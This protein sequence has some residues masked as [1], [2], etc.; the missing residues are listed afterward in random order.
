MPSVYNRQG[1]EQQR[2]R[3]ESVYNGF[4]NDATYGG[5]YGTAVATGV[6]YGSEPSEGVRGA[7]ATGSVRT[8]C[9]SV[10]AGFNGESGNSAA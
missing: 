6:T 1:T 3:A 8:R 4:Q 2:G 7:A 10:Y 5:A 9:D